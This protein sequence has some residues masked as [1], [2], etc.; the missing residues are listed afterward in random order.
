MFVARASGT[1]PARCSGLCVRALASGRLAG[2]RSGASRWRLA[3]IALALVPSLSA[4]GWAL[5]P[6]K[7][8][9]PADR[10]NQKLAARVVALGKQPDAVLPL[11][12]LWSNWDQATP[13]RTFELLRDLAENKKLAPP[14]R[15]A[16]QTV[17]AD[18]Q[19]R[20]GDP[21]ALGKRF[22]E[23]GYVTRWR[24]IGPF[25]NEGKS[26]FDTE[27][28][29][30]AARMQAP[31]LQ[32]SYPGR[33]RPVRW[34]NYPDIARRGYVSFGGLMRPRENACGL[35]ET[36]VYSE[37]AQALSLWLGSGGANKL[38]WNGTEVSRDNAYRLPSPDRSVVMVGAHKGANRVLVKVCVTS[39]TWGFYLRVGDASGAPV[40]GLK[41]EP[42]SEQALEIA[43]GNAPIK[44]PK[45]PLAVLALFEQRAAADKPKGSALAELAKLMRYTGADDP[46]ERRAKQLAAR[47]AELDPKVEHF[48]LAAELAEE[49]A[50]V[51]RFAQQAEQRFPSE[52]GSL[53]LRAKV[54]ATGPAPEDALPLLAKIG[55]G[56]PEWVSAQ[57]MR[58]SILR[59]LELPAAG[60]R[61]LE[62][63]RQAIGETPQLLRA[64]AGAYNA[65][66]A[67][68]LAILAQQRLLAIRFD[69]PGARRVLIAD[70]LQRVQNAQ[71]LEQLDI[72]RKLA[73]GAVDTALYIADV[74]DALGRD[75][76]VLSVYR[77]AMEIV[78][79]SPELLVAYGRALLRAE[80]PELAADA[81]AAAL[82]LKPQD[83]ATRELLE[84]IKPRMREDE[85]YAL[86]SD[87][88]IAAGRKS[89]GYSSTVLT[90]L[91]VNTVFENGLGSS[92][93]QYA[94][95][96]H[97]DEGA[98]RYRTFPIQ[99][100]PD[101]QRVD[102]RLARVY[103]K[104]GQ[105]LESVRSYE[106][107]L[108]EPWYRIY[109]DTRAMVVVL[110]DLDPGDII[111][112]RYRID[113]VAHRN[114]FADYYGD[115]HTW[116]GYV[117]TV[118]SEYVLITPKARAFYRS[119]PTLKGLRFE[120]KVDGNRRIL[121]Y[122]AENIPA[123]V[124]EA[125][126]P[127][128]TETSPY[129]HVSTY[130]TWRDVGRWYW[131]LIKD[132]LYAD[133]SLRA[134]VRDLV[135]DQKTTR[136]KV[137]RIHDWVVS[138]TRYVGLEFG[139]HGFL[140][141]R[142]PLIVQRGFGDCK[143]KASL[144]YT[145]MREAGIDARIVLLRTRR[146]G[147]IGGEPASLSIFDHAIAYVPELDLYIDGTAEHSGIDE[148]P[149]QDQGVTVLVVGPD[150]AELRTTPVFEAEKNRR[151]RTLKVSL[152]TDGSARV[153][154]DEIVVGADAAGYR[155]YY[156]APGTRAERFERSLGSLYPG[157]KLEEQSFSPLDDLDEP[158][159]Y[160]YRLNVPQLARW[161]GDELRLA[162][163]VL[164]DLVQD[165]ARLPAR[166]H[167]L[168]L[169]MNRAYSEE[170][171]V[172]LPAGLVPSDLPAGG[173][174]SSPFG[175]LRLSFSQTAGAIT[176]RTELTVTRDRVAPSEYPE[177]RRWVEAAD[178]LLKQ[179]IGVRKERE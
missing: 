158:V 11:L 91:T 95:Q 66:G 113:D 159:R 153:E 51:M 148:L 13:A 168:D 38:Y 178:Q 65:T 157:L 39:T 58:A 89:S 131:G 135:K 152:A 18:A 41:V 74:Y 147:A 81:F 106:Q 61:V 156:E 44:L 85:A 1:P 59:D 69:D 49:R 115:L 142:V 55:K 79:E 71:V 149:G 130:K 86:S 101:S 17:L 20:M 164:H 50:E 26:G 126:M 33:E 3:L 19:T 173:E 87:K 12:E 73:P 144:L 88:V 31:D 2:T 117:P 127:G 140:P 46:A 53:L 80:R 167:V 171:T 122:V 7:P 43:A 82:A 6:G 21:D 93:R 124:A 63:T 92:F 77:H 119:A 30:E 177:F 27:S 133:E 146:N 9:T 23:L 67:P 107:Q 145:M 138:K 155:N 174:V 134:T 52:P 36:F 45:P 35:A 57:L 4:V 154:G 14:T 56:A 70:A 37:K 10:E 143:D 102:L 170:R 128:L 151:T 99:Y 163:S 100:D 64:L 166:R 104:G 42:T 108:G 54:A 62:D 112:L 98:R 34:R 150:S 97:D 160:S 136:D 129:L 22:E 72:L 83:A 15:I 32:T 25:D 94:V 40:K 24:V 132:Q 111:E 172:R 68:D 179:R 109:Y 123:I 137:E 75:D 141:Y 48:K 29:P 175:R 90:D 176:A 96:V 118:R 120:E 161:D 116:Q 125:D 78:P 114:L 76:M 8:E 165:M 47:A 60:R 5:Q 105:V 103:R 162:P 169:N 139:I 110:P 121:H 16:A 28:P 84:Q